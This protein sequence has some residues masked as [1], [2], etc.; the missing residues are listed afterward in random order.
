MSHARVKAL[1]GAGKTTS[2]KAIKSGRA[3]GNITPQSSPLPSS[4]TSPIHSA[5][6][7]R[8]A[9]DASDNEFDDEPVQFEDTMYGDGLGGTALAIHFMGPSTVIDVKAL[10]DTMR[11][12]KH[13][14]SEVRE[15]I[16]GGYNK[17]LRT[18]FEAETRERWLTSSALELAQFFLRGADRGATARERLLSLQAYY[19]TVGT[20]GDL[21]IFETSERALKQ[22]LIDDDNDEIRVLAIYVL[23]L[24][25]LY[26][27]GLEEAA[28]EV[29]QY[30][31][32]IV[33]TDGDSVELHDNE[34]VVAAAIV[35]WTFVASHVRDFSASAD[36]A[37]N[38]FVEQLD[39]SVVDVQC[40][41]AQAI[42]LIFESAR[43]YEA[44]MG[45]PFQLQCDPQRLAGRMRELIKASSSK[46][47][48][49]KQRRKMRESLASVATSLERGVGPF[50][51]TALLF[52]DHIADGRATI[53]YRNE[54]G[55]PEYGYRCHLRIGIYSTLV[56]TWSLLS[57]ARVMK[58]LFREALQRHLFI[59]P[60]VME[61]LDDAKWTVVGGVRRP[62][63]HCH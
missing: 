18:R 51:S 36:A 27:G 33:Q 61:C 30:L 37:M 57:R 59:N 31:V 1:K 6:H 47:V 60:V 19:L 40:N 23:C 15:K 10:I 7:S 55:E 11:D 21:E 4:H 56:S 2:R 46:S 29:M 22:I 8:A 52:P 26:A 34:A 41:A 63:C 58:I 13:N 53:S 5:A 12:K 49:R 39:S 50:Y 3:S 9:S 48:P 17:V 62:C 44:E 20:T 42:A 35:G 45:E 54:E 25:V 24:T 38:A 32:D 14:N 16:L 28:L 43:N